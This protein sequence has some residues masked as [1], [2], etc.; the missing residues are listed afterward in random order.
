M[1]YLAFHVSQKARGCMS[2][3]AQIDNDFSEDKKMRGV[4]Q[5]GPQNPRFIELTLAFAGI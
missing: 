4:G 3:F 2:L 5:S 1:S